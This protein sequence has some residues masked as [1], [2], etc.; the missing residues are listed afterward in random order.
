MRLLRFE[1]EFHRLHV[2]REKL[3]VALAEAVGVR[4]GELVEETR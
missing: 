3:I 4:P 2:E 1:V